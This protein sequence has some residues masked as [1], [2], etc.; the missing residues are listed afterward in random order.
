MP[1]FN[2][3]VAALSLALTIVFGWSWV[4]AHTKLERSEP[5]EGATVAAP[6][7]QIQIWFNQKPDGKVSRITLTGPSGVVKTSDA[8]V[9]DETSITASVEADTPNGKYSVAWQTAGKDGH[10]QKGEFSFTVLG[11]AQ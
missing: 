2:S 11:K 7:K 3:V 10:V 8:R 1:K 5:M 9:K 4:Q 6:V